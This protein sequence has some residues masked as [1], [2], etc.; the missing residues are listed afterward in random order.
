MESP[1]EPRRAQI[2]STLIIVIILISLFSGA[3]AGYFLSYVPLSAKIHAFKF[4]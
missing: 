3:I 4:E 1:K 2:S